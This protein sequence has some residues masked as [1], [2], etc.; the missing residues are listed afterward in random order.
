[1]FLAQVKTLFVEATREVFDRNHP[2][3]DLRGLHVSQEYPATT[4]HY[5]GIWLNF[6]PTSQL[7]VAGL[8]HTEWIP[9]EDGSFRRGTRWRFG[10]TVQFTVVG[11]S[12]LARDNLVDEI[13]K[14]LAFGTE[15]PALNRFREMIETNDLIAISAQWDTFGID[16]MS[17]TEGTPWG[18]ADIIFE[19][20]VSMDLQG[21]FVAD[22][23]SGESFVPLSRVVI[24]DQ[25]PGED[26]PTFPETSPPGTENPWM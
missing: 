22:F 8:S 23:A 5:P 1:M 20:T 11:L 18:S 26:E 15:N 12:S 24:R 17:E 19:A 6:T 14:V 13:I 2:N 16:G 3:R 21:S 9:N 4:E 25:A 7:Q 10:G